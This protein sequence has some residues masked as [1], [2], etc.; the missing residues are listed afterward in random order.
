MLLV[1]GATGFVGRHV[2]AALHA[3]GVQGIRCLVH[4]PERAAALQR[5]GVEL[6]QGDVLD[7]PSLQRA[8]AGVHTVVDLVAVIREWGRSTFQSINQLGAWNVAEAAKAAGVRHL[9]HMSVVGAGDDLRY[10][11]LRSRWLGEQEVIHSGIPSTVLRFSI[12]FG[13]GDE[14]VNVLAALVKALPVTPVVGNGRNR[15]QPIHVEDVARCVALVVAGEGYRGRA[16]DIGG[17]EYLTYDQLIDIVAEACGARHPKVHV[18]VPLMRPLVALMERVLPRP[19]VTLQQLKLL[20]VDNVTDL[21]SV[22]QNFGFGPRPLRGNIGYVARI[23][24]QD[25]FR[26][27]AGVLPRHIRDH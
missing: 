10:P 18:P 9:V 6:A 24:R 19:P 5:F 16:I 14:F 22:E 7:P 4:T 25:A 2:V 3:A 8:M 11:Y 15:F 13:E 12:G 26:I 1:T 21:N 20:D 23:Q 17:P 27:L